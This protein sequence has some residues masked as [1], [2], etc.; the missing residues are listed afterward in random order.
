[1]TK[2]VVLTVGSTTYS[3]ESVT[4]NYA[5]ESLTL[6]STDNI[7]KCN[8]LSEDVCNSQLVAEIKLP[9][10]VRLKLNELAHRVG[11]CLFEV[12]LKRRAGV[13]FCGFVI[14]KLYSGIT[15]FLYCT[16]LRNNARTSLDNGAWN[17]LSIGTENGSHSDFLSN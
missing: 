15:I 17:I 12:P 11:S 5:L 14:G 4:L 1:M 16:E 10:E 6:R 13:L 2:T 9:C 3:G 7:D 8:A